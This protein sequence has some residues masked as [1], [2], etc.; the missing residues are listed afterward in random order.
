MKRLLDT[1]PLHFGNLKGNE[2]T[3]GKHSEATFECLVFF[4]LSTITCLN[5]MTVQTGKVVTLV[6][7]VS[8][9]LLYTTLSANIMPARE[10][11]TTLAAII[12]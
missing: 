9:P 2:M 11:H 3:V 4:P 8:S 5:Q 1:F 6:L 12:W 7:L 10:V